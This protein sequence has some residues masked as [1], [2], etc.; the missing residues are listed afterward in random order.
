M[1]P[2]HSN[3]KAYFDC[4][5]TTPTLP[6]AT[7]AAVEAMQWLYGNPSSAHLTGLQAKH[8][9]ETTRKL[10]AKVITALPEEI[11]FTS[12]A[13]EAIQTAVFSAIHQGRSNTK[14][15][16][17]LYLSTEHKAVPQALEHWAKALNPNLKLVSIPVDANGIIDLDF[18]KKEAKEA[19]LICTMAV[20]NETGVKQDLYAIEKVIRS[21]N[22]EALW[23][24]DSVQALGKMDLDFSKLSVSY[25]TFSGHKLYAPKGIGFLYARKSAPFHPLLVGGG[26]ERG[27]RSGTEN[28][29][30]VAAL[31]AV[32]QAMEEKTIFHTEE[33]LI[34][35]R[36]QIVKTLKSAFPS[37]V[38]NAPFK[39]SVPTTIN[40]SVKGFASK[41]LL[42]LFD[43]GGLR[44]SSGSACS[45]S[46]VSRSYVLDAMGV[47]EWQSLSAMRLSFGP[48]TTEE[49]IAVGCKAILDAALALSSSCL[50]S[51]EGNL[52]APGNLRD[53]LIQLRAGASNTWIVANKVARTCVIIDPCEQLAER[54][55]NYVKCQKIK[56]LAIL[57]THT[58]G[59]HES[60]RPFLYKILK[61]DLASGLSTSTDSLGWRSTSDEITLSNGTTV[62]A[63]KVTESLV[64]AKLQT[65]GHTED[66]ATLLLGT[67][68]NG[69]L[70]RE[71][72]RFAFCGD[73]VL[74]GGIGRTNFECSN[75]N[76]IFHS[77]RTLNNVLGEKTLLCPAHDYNNSFATTWGAEKATN[78]LLSEALDPIE[79]LAEQ[80]FVS[81]KKLLDKDLCALEADFQGIVCGVTVNCIS[82][83]K[84]S[85]S[86][87]DL[88]QTMKKLS[89]LIIDVREPQEFALCK[90]WRELGFST[91]PRNVPLSRFVNFIAEILHTNP[92]PNILC[93]CRSGNRS[94][95]ATQA[96]RRLGVENVW[97]VEGGIAIG[98]NFKHSLSQEPRAAAL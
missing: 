41:E 25:A 8:L 24:V 21:A 52:E 90:D 57:D 86:P 6:L 32:L 59:D 20:N 89:P 48:A 84:V 47:P 85:V 98:C 60:V 37:V 96:L 26:Q 72:T 5:A 67:S 7:N 55:V 49:E 68:S 97:N 79:S 18:L 43:A 1:L 69:T 66:S 19:L 29:P 82:P 9:L 74:T 36:E 13:T 61:D 73:T 64:L 92:K 22:P 65:P 54:I 40:F 70:Q 42:D 3:T 12:G 14:L 80:K 17:L 77:L 50:L 71:N 46:K 2:S 93:I 34:E 51:R 4:N 88:Q 62:P 95:Y 78:Q 45:S 87:G 38:F 81:K 10:A 39:Y 23:L 31:G 27:L 16:K 58:H 91:E 33:K 15:S 44:V 56:V 30:G 28:L 53:G 76:S 63:L 75:V 35:L 94:L 83:E 11:I